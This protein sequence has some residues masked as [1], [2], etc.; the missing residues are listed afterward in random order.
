MVGIIGPSVANSWATDY[1]WKVAIQMPAVISMV[2]ATALYF[3][4]FDK[5][6]DVGYLDQNFGGGMCT[7]NCLYIYIYI[8]YF[9]SL[10]S[11]ILPEITYEHI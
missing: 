2:L 10:I 5:P 1:G 4:V 3:T 9:Y 8:S 6:S 7:I 11:T